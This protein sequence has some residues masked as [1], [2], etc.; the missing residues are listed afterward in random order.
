MTPK[1]T[2]LRAAGAF[3]VRSSAFAK[4]Q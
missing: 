1:G 4:E 3:G 2:L